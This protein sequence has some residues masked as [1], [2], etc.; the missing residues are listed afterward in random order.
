MLA[1]AGPP[2]AEGWRALELLLEGEDVAVDQL[3]GLGDG[4]EILEPPELR[5]RLHELGLQMARR[6]APRSCDG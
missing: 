1:E 3:A 4:V 5:R 6:N 2:D